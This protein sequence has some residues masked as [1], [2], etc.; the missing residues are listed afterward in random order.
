MTATLLLFL[1]L[2]IAVF[3]ADRKGLPGTKIALCILGALAI[4]VAVVRMTRVSREQ[5][6]SPSNILARSMG[7]ML[8]RTAVEAFP[9]GG[10]VLV[11][12]SHL[13]TP[14]FQVMHEAERAGLEQALKGSSLRVA[15]V[16]PANREEEGVSIL[17]LE[18]A[19]AIPYE[20]FQSY[21]RSY[22]DVLVIISFTGLPDIA[23]DELPE[24][25]P[26]LL[27][28]GTYDLEQC[29]PWLRGGKLLATVCYRPDADWA[30][31]PEPDD[32]EE[33]AFNRW[34]VL[35]TPE[36]LDAELSRL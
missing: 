15:A 9:D 10:E 27:V 35:V 19:M 33:T 11:V 18:A 20:D 13:N 8:G 30:A 25:A 14:R 1:V 34:H 12:Q 24:D 16:E 29:A 17:E 2:L 23:I 3:I 21:L 36:N 22:P 6:R 7:Y 26:G 5:A 31:L 32:T 4:A 28:Y